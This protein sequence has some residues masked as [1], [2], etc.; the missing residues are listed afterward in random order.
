MSAFEWQVAFGF[1]K[2]VSEVL[3]LKLSHIEH[4]K[5][6]PVMQTKTFL[7]LTT[8]AVTG[9]HCPAASQ[10]LTG[11]SKSAICNKLFYFFIY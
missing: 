9:A 1:Q 6:Q 2:I 7:A 3:G 11:A 4:S 10:M 5:Q 8:T